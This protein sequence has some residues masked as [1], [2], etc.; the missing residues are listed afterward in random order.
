MLACLMVQVFGEQIIGLVILTILTALLCLKHGIW[1]K[2]TEK[3]TRRAQAM[4]GVGV[5]VQNNTRLV[6]QRHPS[7]A[8]L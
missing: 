6:A 5:G 8:L 3:M 7:F 1:K 2:K 4:W